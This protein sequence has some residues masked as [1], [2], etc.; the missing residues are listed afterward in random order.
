MSEIEEQIESAEERLSTA[1]LLLGEG[2]YE[3]VVSRAYYS[4]F[5]AAK[6][7]LLFKDSKPRTHAGIASELGKLFRDELGPRLTSKFSTIQQLREDADYGI[8]SDIEEE[9]AEEVVKTSEKFLS[10]AKKIVEKSE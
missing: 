9:R 10:E 1:K 5:H 7:L 4:M 6:A 8:E 2:R 3:D